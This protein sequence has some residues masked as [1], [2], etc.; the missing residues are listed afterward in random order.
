MLA[1]YRLILEDRRIRLNFWVSKLIGK[2]STSFKNPNLINNIPEKEKK[3][4]KGKHFTLSR[5]DPIKVRNEEEE[6]LK[7]LIIKH[8]IFIK[9]KLTDTEINNKINKLLSYNFY[10]VS[11]IGDK[12]T[13]DMVSNM[14]L[15][16][17]HE[18]EDLK[19]KEKE[20]MSNEENNVD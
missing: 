6:R 14:I 8:P 3:N 2:P 12:D 13:T 5:T 4:L 20:Y 16:R 9:E 18:L 7:G 17:D 10:K 15:L 1:N 11:N 19:V